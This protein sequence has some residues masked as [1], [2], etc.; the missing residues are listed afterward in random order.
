M[1]RFLTVIFTLVFVTKT[2]ISF[3]SYGSLAGL[4]DE[5]LDRIIPALQI[6]DS[7]P[8]PRPL[9][10]TS[11]KLVNDKDHPWKPLRPGTYGDLVPV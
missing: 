10:D 3:P 7:E 9:N 1:V 4:S 2:A 5:E 8:P 11:A 6:R